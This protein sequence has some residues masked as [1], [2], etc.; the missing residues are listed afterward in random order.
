LLKLR[1]A[2]RWLSMRESSAPSSVLSAATRDATWVK[3]SGTDSRTRPFARDGSETSSSIVTVD[4]GV[5]GVTER[6][7]WYDIEDP[8]HRKIPATPHSAEDS[9]SNGDAV[10]RSALKGDEPEA[11]RF[12]TYAR[13]VELGD[14]L[15][16]EKVCLC[17]FCTLGE[18][19]PRSI[20]DSAISPMQCAK[21]A[22][23]GQGG[24]SHERPLLVEARVA[25]SLALANA[26]SLFLVRRLRSD[27]RGRAMLERLSARSLR[28]C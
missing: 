21:S 18:K 27:E 13:A 2:I 24:F 25:S 12:W 19:R 4:R 10:S 7:S 14:H 11:T 16:E 8:R 5:L 15:A 23:C 6:G 26:R 22:H 3:S 1:A 9:L 28:F 20:A 17:T